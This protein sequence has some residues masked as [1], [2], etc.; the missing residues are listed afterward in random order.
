MRFYRRRALAF[1]RDQPGTKAKLAGVAARML[2]Q[3][4]V[5]RTEGRRGR[6]T[7]L[8]TARIWIEPV[9]AIPLFVLALV[10]VP[11]LPRRLAV[12]A[13]LLLAYETVAAMAFAGE[14]RY[15]FGDRT[16]AAQANEIAAH[17]FANG[18]NFI[19][20]ADVYANGASESIT[21]AAI[22]AQ[23]STWILATKVGNPMAGEG[24]RHRTPAGSRG[25]GSCRRA[26][27][28]SRAS[29]AT[30]S[31]STTCTST[32]RRRRSPKRWRRWVP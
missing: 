13:A 15:M 19:D 30:G 5:T 28:A 32:T 16:D 24:N 4:S 11:F 2:W 25:A 14:T 22:R 26:T 17:A 12:L 20:T 9:Y 10:G 23:R 1:I 6:G 31:T 8:D 18:I 3:P 27:R 29:G 21:G 7:F